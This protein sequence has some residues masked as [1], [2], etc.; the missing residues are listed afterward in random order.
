MR[1]FLFALLGITACLLNVTTGDAS[2]TKPASAKTATSSKL[3]NIVLIMADDL[4]YAELGCYGQKIIKTPHI[5]KLAAEG[6]KL[7]QF[8]SGSPVCASTRCCL[9]TGKHTGHSFTRSNGKVRLV[10]GTAE[11]KRLKKLNNWTFYGQCPVPATE[12]TMA[13]VLKQKGYATGAMGKWGLGQ[14]GTSGDPNKRGFDLFYGYNCQVHAHNHYPRFLWRNNKKELLP[15]NDR[16][17]TGKTYS[18]D[19]F[20]ETALQFIRDNKSKPFFLYLPFAIPHLSIQVPEKSLAQYKGKIKESGPYNSGGHYLKHPFPRA[21]YAAMVSH[22]DRDVGKV[23]ALL[24]KLNLD[25]N[26]LVIFTSDNGPTFDRLGGADSTFFNSAG[27]FRGRKCSVYDGG[28]HVP[29]VARWPGKIAPKTVSGHLSAIWDLLPTFA[30]ITGTKAP[31]NIDGISLAD[32]LLGNA[33][34]QKQHDHLYWE[35]TGHGGQQALRQGNWKVVRQNTSKAKK[36]ADLK[37]ELYDLKNDPGE[38]TN[39]AAKFPQRVKEMEK[40]MRSAR[41]PSKIFKLPAIDREWQ[42]HAHERKP[43]KSSSEK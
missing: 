11:M 22:M 31:K 35:Y 5:D 29:M 8:Y 1:C 25:K 43:Q 39:V 36:T 6:M 12:V 41:F 15:G 9:M 26:T 37:T 27:P 2:E 23:M 7:T 24:K 16:K 18:Q 13:E 4:G 28:I 30:E 10:V 21:G 33:K 20:T 14:F 40:L 42:E 3:P 17:S 19:K 38:K 34:K 32:T